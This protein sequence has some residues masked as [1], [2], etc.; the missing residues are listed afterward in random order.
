MTDL[1]A[2]AKAL[3]EAAY[4]HGEKPGAG[5]ECDNETAAWT[6]FRAAL[7]ANAA[8]IERLANANRDAAELH[9]ADESTILH[10]TTACERLTKALERVVAASRCY[11]DPSV[12]S[13][14]PCAHCQATEAIRA[15]Q[16]SPAVNGGE[17]E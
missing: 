1:A 6:A 14:P 4:A 9:L 8:E 13:P 11:C 15:H 5:L 3:R 2:L 17:D 10:L 16:P 12:P 7:S